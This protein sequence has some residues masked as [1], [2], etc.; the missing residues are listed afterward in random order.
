MRR[1][2]ASRRWARRM[3]TLISSTMTLLGPGLSVSSWS[4][5]LALTARP[6]L[7][8]ATLTLPFPCR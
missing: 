2:T 6:V 3:R 7:S 4:L 1:R 8:A 5:S